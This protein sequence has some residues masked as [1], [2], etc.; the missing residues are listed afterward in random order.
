MFHQHEIPLNYELFDYFA[1]TYMHWWVEGHQVTNG[2]WISNYVLVI[3]IKVCNVQFLPVSYSHIKKIRAPSH[4]N[5]S[6]L[7]EANLGSHIYRQY[8]M[9]LSGGEVKTVWLTTILVE[10]LKSF[11]CKIFCWGSLK[12]FFF[13]LLYFTWSQI[14]STSIPDNNSFI[15]HSFHCNIHCAVMMVE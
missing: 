4:W 13:A 10:V 5:F 15:A 1:T 9:C 8:I 7:E 12:L 6:W 14:S 2:L 3:A 11:Q